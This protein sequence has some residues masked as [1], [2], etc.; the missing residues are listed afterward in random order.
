VSSSVDVDERIAGEAE[1]DDN[2]V[3][4]EEHNV[5]EEDHRKEL[6]EDS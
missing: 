5:D 4:T 6:E 3:V 2:V 1:L